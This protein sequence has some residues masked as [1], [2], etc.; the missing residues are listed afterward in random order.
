MFKNMTLRL[1]IFHTFTSNTDKILSD[2]FCVYNQPMS[3]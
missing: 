1:R 3:I 2:K